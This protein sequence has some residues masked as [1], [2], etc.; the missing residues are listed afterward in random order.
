MPLTGIAWICGVGCGLLRLRV[1]AGVVG[2]AVVSIGQ[3]M[4]TVRCLKSP[5]NQD[6]WRMTLPPFLQLFGT[7]LHPKGPAFCSLNYRD[8]HSRR[9]S[10]MPTGDAAPSLGK[11][12][13]LALPLGR[14]KPPAVRVCVP[15]HLGAQS[16]QP[17]R[18]CER[19]IPRAGGGLHTRTPPTRVH[20]SAFPR[21]DG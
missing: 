9:G 14:C 2:C 18:D 12:A 4:D 17:G 11:P 3:T 15:V 13:A 6:E 1:P 5:G 20:L 8:A 16:L 7:H 21:F 19:S 10:D